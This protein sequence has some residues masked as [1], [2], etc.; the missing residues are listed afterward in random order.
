[1]SFFLIISYESHEEDLKMED[2]LLISINFW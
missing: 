1:M 2:K